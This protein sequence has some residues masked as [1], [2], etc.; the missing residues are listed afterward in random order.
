[1]KEENI[2][3]TNLIVVEMRTRCARRHVD[4]SIMRTRLNWEENE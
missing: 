4:L 2:V 1:M 3:I